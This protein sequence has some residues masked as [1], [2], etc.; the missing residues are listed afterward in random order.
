VQL[1]RS[2]YKPVGYSRLRS[3]GIRLLQRL[4]G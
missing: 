1:F 3:F 2:H 4:T